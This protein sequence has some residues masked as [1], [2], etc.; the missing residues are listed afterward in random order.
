MMIEP[1]EFYANPQTMATNVYQ[2]DQENV[3]AKTI[4]DNALSEF[5]AYRDMLVE[6]GVIVTTA[7]GY[8]DCPD[9]VFPNW[10]STHAGG[11]MVLYPML[12]DNRRAERAPE[13]IEFLKKS[14]PDIIDLTEYEKEGLFLEARGSIVSDR[15]NRVG[16]VA[17]SDRTS[18]AMAEKWAEI[19]DYELEIFDTLSHTGKPVY[20]TDLLIY[21]GSTMA[22][23][24][25]PAIIDKDRARIVERLK[26]THEVVEFSMEQLSTFCGNSL[27]VRG[28]G[29]QKML[30]MSSAAYNA[31]TDEQLAVMKL[32][33]SRILHAPLPTLEKYGGGSARCT[34]MELY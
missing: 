27:E 9:M 18:R 33:F 29:N 4:N 8:K 21:I 20:H 2:V 14:Y 25:S 11:R 19:M 22:G 13:V 32:H 7:Y 15:V 6:N 5:R 1:A 12:S 30:A 31:L 23:V 34:L 3:Q 24:V 10:A 17:L 16:Y 26:S 28:E